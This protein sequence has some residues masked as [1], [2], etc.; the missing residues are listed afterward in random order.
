MRA[1]IVL[2]SELNFTAAAKI[3]NI[4]QPPLTR[5]ISNLELNLGI[6]LFKRTTRKV[7]LTGAGIYLL[8]EGKRIIEATEK[9]EKELKNINKSKAFT[10]KIGLSSASIHSSIPKIISAYKEQFPKVNIDLNEIPTSKGL[11]LLKN[12]KVNIVITSKDLKSELIE[13]Q[14]IDGQE[15]GFIVHKSNKNLQG[16]T[17]S[18]KQLA[19]EIFIF[20]P[21]K[22]AL[23]FQQDFYSLL[24]KKGIQPQIYYKGVNESCINLVLLNKGILLSTKKMA[25]L[26]ELLRFIPLS[27]FSAKFNIYVSWL[28]HDLNDELKSFI[29]FLSPNIKLPES[30]AGKH[31]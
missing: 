15:L 11:S 9:L 5:M 27:D 3:L 29:S 10:I 4:T 12:N 16:K 30:E 24:Q 18:Y 19:S 13:S 8:S 23:G 22:Q 7:E 21:K 26:S 2:A 14:I 28:K 25:M 20:H 31:F 1:F 6:K 17:I